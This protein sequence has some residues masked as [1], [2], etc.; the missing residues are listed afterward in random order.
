MDDDR[1]IH[2]DRVLL[3]E[4]VEPLRVLEAALAVLLGD[5]Y[6]ACISAHRVFAGPLRVADPREV[7]A[8][9]GLDERDALASIVRLLQT[10]AA[11]QRLL[12]IGRGLGDVGLGDR[13]RGGVGAAVAGRDD[14]EEG[15]HGG[16]PEEGSRE[17]I[18]ALHGCTSVL[19]V[20]LGR[21]RGRVRTTLES[22]WSENFTA[23][24]PE[25]RAY[26]PN[27]RTVFLFLPRAI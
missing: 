23:H 24:T 18:P 16:C 9:V 5:P 25:C 15:S 2:V 4:E 13:R 1:S 20:A 27:F 6:L 14:G 26:R 10:G 22:V 3:G 8:V 21:P 12:D 19:W 11:G 7:G 17:Q